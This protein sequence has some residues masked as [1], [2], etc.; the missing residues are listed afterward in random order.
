MK[1]PSTSERLMNV[2]ERA[3][4]EG[5]RVEDV[6]ECK[7]TIWVTEISMIEVTFG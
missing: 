7:W 6:M 4:E 3:G 1:Q 5:E 2:E